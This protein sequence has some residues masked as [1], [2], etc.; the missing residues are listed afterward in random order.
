MSHDTELD[1]ILSTLAKP[2]GRL[3][4]TLLD[5]RMWAHSPNR[6]GSCIKAYF[7]LL[8]EAP[9]TAEVARSLTA[10]R[11]WLESKLNILVFDS[12]RSVCLDTLPLALSDETD[13]EQYC[14]GAMQRLR[15]DR[16]HEVP[17]LRLEFSFSG[18]R[19]IAA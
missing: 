19:Q 13:L 7:D 15:D 18:N 11:N 16:C 10:L 12:A 5:L 2:L 3:S 14:H 9:E 6:A 8:G 17:H 1:R 4:D